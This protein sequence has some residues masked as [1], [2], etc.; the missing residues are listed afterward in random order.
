MSQSYRRR[1]DY[2]YNRE[3]ALSEHVTGR[4]PGALTCEVGMHLLGPLAKLAKTFPCPLPLQSWRCPRV[5]KNPFGSRR[6]LDG[7]PRYEFLEPCSEELVENGR[8]ETA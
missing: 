1:P 4:L 3:A 8:V 5:R 2:P 6:L 7:Y